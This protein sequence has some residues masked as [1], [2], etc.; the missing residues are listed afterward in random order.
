MKLYLAYIR[1]TEGSAPRPGSRLGERVLPGSNPIAGFGLGRDLIAEAVEHRRHGAD[2]GADVEM[3]DALA[4]LS[5][6]GLKADCEDGAELIVGGPN[7]PLRR[8]DRDR[9][10]QPMRVASGGPGEAVNM[11]D[12][13]AVFAGFEALIR[14]AAACAWRRRRRARSCR[15]GVG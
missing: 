8:A 4:M 15:A 3:G 2:D 5:V 11:I 9:C 12:V 7:S 13:G 14:C 6:E 1:P 10:H